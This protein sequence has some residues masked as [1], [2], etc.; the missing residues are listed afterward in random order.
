MLQDFNEI[1][2][3]FEKLHLLSSS[4]IGKK[5][6]TQKA[7]IFFDVYHHKVLMD[8]W[9]YSELNFHSLQ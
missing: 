8:I 4:F 3:T 7:E 5:I 1:I 6:V 9:K 2:P